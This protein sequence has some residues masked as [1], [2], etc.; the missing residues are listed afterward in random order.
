MSS[1]LENISLPAKSFKRKNE[2]KHG[3]GMPA[4]AVMTA[5]G[6]GA[7]LLH[8]KLFNKSTGRLGK[9]AKNPTVDILDIALK[10]TGD[11]ALKP[12]QKRTAKAALNLLKKAENALKGKTGE[13]LTVAENLKEKHIT[14]AV[15]FLINGTKPYQKASFVGALAGMGIYAFHRIFL[16]KENKI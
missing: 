7:G 10:K 8:S 4:A 14:K 2:D 16:N 15:N 13:A 1:Y 9:Y 6:A 11:E 5:S 3:L 12:E